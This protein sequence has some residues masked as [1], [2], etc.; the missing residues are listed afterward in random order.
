LTEQS[1][2]LRES[3]PRGSIVNRSCRPQSRCDK[4]IMMLLHGLRPRASTFF[5]KISN[6]NTYFFI[7]PPTWLPSSADHDD[8]G[9]GWRR[10][11]SMCHLWH[12]RRWFLEPYNSKFTSNKCDSRMWPSIVSRKT[13]DAR[14]PRRA[15]I[16]FSLVCFTVVLLVSKEN[17]RDERSFLVPFVTQSSSASHSRRGRWT[18]CSVKRIPAGELGS[19]KYSTRW[20]VILSRWK[21]TTI[22]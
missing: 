12:S 4:S 10:S 5:S 11:L 14:K 22:I 6:P 1:L 15:S 16:H 21:S 7:L 8:D 20:K 13:S 18:M 3:Q 19:Q 2:G 17:C 9:R